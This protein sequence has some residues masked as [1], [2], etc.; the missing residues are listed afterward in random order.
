MG[1][2][3]RGLVL[4]VA[5]LGFI[6]VSGTA[7]I[8]HAQRPDSATPQAYRTS[9][10]LL[11]LNV[12]VLDQQRRP[13]RGLTATDFTVL[14]DGESRPIVALHMADFAT[15]HPVAQPVWQHE[16]AEDVASNAPLAG[17]MVVI[18]FDRSIEPGHPTAAARRIAARAIDELGPDDV[19]AVVYNSYLATPVNFTRDHK[20]LLTAIESPVIGTQRYVFDERAREN[21]SCFCNLCGLEIIGRIAE[22]LQAAVN[23]PK[24]LLYIGSQL[25]MLEDPAQFCAPWSL[26]LTDALFAAAQR[27][28]VVIHAVDPKGMTS[29]VLIGDAPPSISSVQSLL[30]LADETGGRA[31]RNSNAPEAIVPRLFEE[32]AVSYLLGFHPKW[33]IA[34]GKLHRVRVEVRG[35][36]RTV[37]APAGYRLPAPMAMDAPRASLATER[38]IA[39]LTPMS[40]LDM[41]ATSFAVPD[42][43]RLDRAAVATV[44]AIRDAPVTTE[45]PITTRVNVA[46]FDTNGRQLATDTQTLTLTPTAGQ[47]ALTYEVLSRFVLPPGRFEI[48]ARVEQDHPSLVGSVFT[49]LDVENYSKV[50][51]AVSGLAFHVAPSPRL[52]ASPALDTWLLLA[53]TTAR[54]FDRDARVTAYIRLL[55]P[56][57]VAAGGVSVMARIIDA[58]GR[59]VI[60]MPTSIRSEDFT[61]DRIA[62]YQFRLPLAQL[63]AGQYLV[64]IDLQQNRINIQR[65][66]RFEVR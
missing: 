2:H 28:Q 49:F 10:D 20:R 45:V 32:S 17:R 33:T 58:Q 1:F 60:T 63:P 21:S 43:Q 3:R 39:G 18:F 50:P 13:V 61:Q 25:P 7:L 46:A 9:V 22:L 54:A 4:R 37:L 40:A 30:R 64:T 15:G 14:E 41:R 29:G 35:T 36:G 53:P 19:A 56:K 57:T 27:A 66:A 34:D 51:L 24:M 5:A 8:T 11:T 65:A 6:G 16:V 59:D 12:T 26:P 42:P 62:D 31:V 48:R 23:R 55:T 38:A 47:T 44:L 52:I